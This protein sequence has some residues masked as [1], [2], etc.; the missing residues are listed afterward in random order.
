[1]RKRSASNSGEPMTWLPSWNP[2]GERE[3]LD[4]SAR[5]DVVVP[6][7]FAVLDPHVA[8]Q[9]DQEAAGHGV[10]ERGTP[11]DGVL[12]AAVQRVERLRRHRLEPVGKA[13]CRRHRRR[14]HAFE[15]RRAAELQRHGIVFT[16][17]HVL[18]Q[19]RQP[20]Q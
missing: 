10:D 13:R 9:R 19:G 12:V 16:G 17:R 8:D 7:E 11:L 15:L 4:G 1:M 18:L 3:K 20:D 6:G 5:R 14:Q 2:I